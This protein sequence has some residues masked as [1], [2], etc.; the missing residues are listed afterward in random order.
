MTQ[1]SKSSKIGKSGK[2]PA[3]TAETPPAPEVFTLH[4]V[5][6]AG[7]GQPLFAALATAIPGLGR[8]HAREAIL[9]GLVTAGKTTLRAPN[10]IMEV[11]TFIHLDL[12]QGIRSARKAQES[13][14][15]SGTT[16]K[17]FTI[18]HEDPHVLVVDKAAGV[19]SAPVREDDRDDEDGGHVAE[20]LRTMWRSKG[21]P[22]VFIGQIH[23][24]DQETSGCLCFAMARTAQRVLAA[25]FSGDAAGR[26]YRCI[27]SGSPRADSGTESNRLGRGD[28]GRRSVVDEDAPGK[29]AVTHWKVIQR[30][31]VC[32]ELEVRL[33][34]GRTHQIRVH[35]AAIG[36]AVLGDRLY[37][38]QN[39]PAAPRVPRLM[40][41]AW[42]LELD[43]PRTGLRLSVTAPLPAIFAEVIASVPPSPHARR[44]LPSAESVPPTAKAPIPGKPA[45]RV[46]AT[47][48][49]ARSDRPS[50]P[51]R[52]SAEPARSPRHFRESNQD[53]SESSRK[54]A[55]SRHSERTAG[56]GAFKA[57]G[58]PQ[59]KSEPKGKD[60]PK[61]K[62]E[63]K[64]KAAYKAKGDYKAK[65][66]AKDEEKSQGEHK[67]KGDYKAKSRHPGKA[68]KAGKP[69]A[70]KVP[71]KRAIT[72]IPRSPTGTARKPSAQPP[73]D[74]S[75]KP[76]R[77]R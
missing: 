1:V 71:K 58:E 25:Q 55:P 39:S 32:S 68:G 18:L 76:R 30:H 62:S 67:A 20:H 7:D 69:D 28:D 73:A 38:R 65:D 10:L 35:L 48:P 77:P 66:K 74:T 5:S 57:H 63:P 72:V 59:G 8:R 43:H 42:K 54:S 33:E 31:G 50:R 27:V 37:G 24:L 2:S 16:F 52:D 22:A 47:A 23:R 45:G 40:L 75:G 17:P 70:L 36:H 14:V 3:S 46:A 44:P 12:R 9:A 13:G 6:L 34:T 64:N 61:G 21:R 15:A 49:D 4:E 19:L 11:A 29:D 56:K 53:T 51:S 26:I 60:E 41:H